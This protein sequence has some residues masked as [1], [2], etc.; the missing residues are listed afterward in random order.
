LK[1]MPML[2]KIRTERS[3]SAIQKMR[4]NRRLY[5]NPVETEI[6]LKELNQDVKGMVN[7]TPKVTPYHPTARRKPL[8][9]RDVSKD[10]DVYRLAYS[11]TSADIPVSFWSGLLD[12]CRIPF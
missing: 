11:M 4:E 12:E 5:W 1:F 8:D 7:N 2:P 9:Q 10:D 6:E 3:S